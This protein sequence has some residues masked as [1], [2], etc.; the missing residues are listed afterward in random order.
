MN[1]LWMTYPAPSQESSP[2]FLTFRFFRHS[3][4]QVQLI[5][6]IDSIDQIFRFSSRV[7]SRA[8]WRC[9]TI[10]GL[11]CTCWRWGSIPEFRWSVV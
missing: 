8:R 10:R 6:L 3:Q 5:R 7:R 1:S 4:N 2:D 9:W 11:R